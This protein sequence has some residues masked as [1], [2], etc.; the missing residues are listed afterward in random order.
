MDSAEMPKYL[1]VMFNK[2]WKG[3]FK[4]GYTT[5]LTSR[6]CSSHEHHSSLT[7][8]KFVFEM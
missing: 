3:K 1:Y 6:I 5:K 7:N 2:D 8:Y 4:F